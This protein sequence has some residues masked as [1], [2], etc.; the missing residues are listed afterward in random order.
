MHLDSGFAAHTCGVDCGID[1]VILPLYLDRILVVGYF[2]PALVLGY[3]G[4][5][6]GSSLSLC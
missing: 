4:R 2:S 6:I 1:S 3:I 5:E